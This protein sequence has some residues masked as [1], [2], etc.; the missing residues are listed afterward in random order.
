MRIEPLRLR[1]LELYSKARK[2]FKIGEHGF[3]SVQALCDSMPDWPLDLF[4]TEESDSLGLRSNRARYT[5]DSIKVVLTGLTISGLLYGGL[6]LLAWGMPFASGAERSLWRFSGIILV[7]T[8]L[9]FTGL[10]G[11][12]KAYDVL[13]LEIG[14]AFST[15]VWTLLL[16]FAYLFF[17]TVCLGYPLART[18]LVVECFLQL[19]R[20]PASAYEIPAWS[21]YFPHIS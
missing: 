21:I 5:D 18:Y 3:P 16:V 14:S 1:R 6:Y 12:F 13:D 9:G 20:L 4:T 15:P 2:R 8:G 17:I 19:S 7:S 10:T 11:L